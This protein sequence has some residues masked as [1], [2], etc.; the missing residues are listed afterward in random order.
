M[1]TFLSAYAVAPRDSSMLAPDDD[2]RLARLLNDDDAAWVA[3]HNAH[4]EP[5]ARLDTAHGPVPTLGAIATAPVVLLA[6]HPEIDVATPSSAYGFRRAGWPFALLHPD[7]PAGPSGRWSRR[8]GS[9]V[10][11]F[12]A[13]HVAHSVAVVFLTPWPSVRF[14]SGLPLP[15]WNRT[16]ELATRAAQRDAVLVV[17][18]A[19][20][21]W[22]DFPPIAA[23]PAT[24][25][26]VAPLVDGAELDAA[27]VGPEA[28]EMIGQ[29]ISVHAWL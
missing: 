26:C 6:A 11:R 7:A 15:S 24:R 19:V 27:V 9:L 29:R 8:L 13:R 16:R 21:A 10:H 2:G 22:S 3:L 18:D 12:G 5:G 25:R 20:D 1:V 28:W 14:A 4:A 17:V 23:L